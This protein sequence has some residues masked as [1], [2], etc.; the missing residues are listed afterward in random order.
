MMAYIILGFLCVIPSICL[1]IL[2]DGETQN[3]TLRDKSVDTETDVFRQLLNQETLIRMSLVK[4]VHSLMKDMIE[5][6]ESM[7]ASNKRLHD[8]E[9]EISSLKNEVQ[10]LKTENQKFKEQAVKF[11]DDFRTTDSRFNEIEGNFTKVSQSQTQYE[12]HVNDKIEDFEKNTSTILNDIKIEVRY[13]SVTLLDLNK[14][15]MELNMSIPEL[16]ESR[17]T[18]FTANVNRSVGDINHKLLTSKDYQ[19]QLI[20]NLSTLGNE[21]SSLMKI[22]SDNL[23]NTINSIKAD[24]EQSQKS[25]LKL[26]AAVSSLEVFRMNMSLLNNCVSKTSV[27]FTVGVTSSSTT[28]SG[29]I[30]VFPHVVTNN[31]NGYTPSTGKF[32]APTDGTYVFFVTVNTYDSNYIYLDLVLNGSNKV[33]T[34]S[35]SSASF[36]TGTNM[37]VL[38]LYTGNSVWVS[39]YNGK[40]YYTDSVP[41]TTFSGFLL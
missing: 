17:I 37:A 3:G 31:G 11:Q 15:T 26:S 19:E 5:M 34:M 39:C 8:A 10:L 38:Q 25:Q 21:Q 23:N 9:K 1:S 16:I 4:N 2:T 12:R 6:K 41:I 14:H 27:G 7:S 13:L 35:H 29:N 20:Y 18:D 22:I 28:W 24:V 33:R 40:S 36:M 32:T 30:L